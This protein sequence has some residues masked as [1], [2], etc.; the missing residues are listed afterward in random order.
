MK[1]CAENGVSG[2]RLAHQRLFQP[3]SA[4]L[5]EEQMEVAVLENI[6]HGRLIR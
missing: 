2:A 6:E 3:L 1:Y 4:M 5:A